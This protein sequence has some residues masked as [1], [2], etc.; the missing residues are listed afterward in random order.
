M[1]LQGRPRGTEV[2][3]APPL[4]TPSLGVQP[5]LDSLVGLPS[6]VPGSDLNPL[7]LYL[8][9]CKVVWRPQASP[10]DG[11]CA[12]VAGILHCYPPD[13]ELSPSPGLEARKAKGE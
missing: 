10:Q 6:S 2:N 5:G 11:R 3:P 9:T 13:T 12:R 7:Y 8:L 4:T 1:R